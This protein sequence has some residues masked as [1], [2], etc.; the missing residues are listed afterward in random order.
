MEIELLRAE[1][2]A[3]TSDVKIM[4]SAKLCSHAHDRGWLNISRSNLAMSLSELPPEVR[5]RSSCID[6][7]HRIMAGYLR[8]VLAGK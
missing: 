1:I 5:K 8:E 2:L 6:V 4:P 3:M 7:Q